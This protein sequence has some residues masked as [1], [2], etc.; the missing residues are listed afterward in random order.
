MFRHRRQRHAYFGPKEQS[1]RGEFPEK[2]RQLDDLHRHSHDFLRHYRYFRYLRPTALLFTLII[3]YLLFSWVGFK[4]IGIFFAALIIMKEIV[5]FFFLLRL[6][7]RI[8]KPMENLKQGLDEVAKGN[9]D[10]KIAYDKP[11]DLDFLI[12]SFN[13]MTAKLSESEKLQAEYEENRKAL[14]ANIS[15]DLKTPIT[16]IQGYI[17]A[18]LD[19]TATSAEHKNKYLKTIHQNSIY[20]NKLIDDLFLFSKL[21][22]QKLDFHYEDIHIRAF[23]DDLMEEYRFDLEERNIRAEYTVQLAADYCIKFDGKRFH[24]A[25]NNLI[26]NAVQHGPET[27]LSIQVKLYRQNDFVCLDVQ[28]NGLGI[29]EDKLPFIFDRFYR[30]ETE[31]PK[32][33]S[34]TGLGLAIAKELVEAQGGKITV[35]SIKNEGTCFTIMLPILR[36][37]EGE[38]Y[39]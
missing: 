32:G 27:D 17:E 24:Q 34:C 19:G 13:E 20:V 14:I 1:R 23:M 5:Q 12:E 28:D 16:A 25:F 2:F 15:H 21:D 30:I 9:Y 37:S 36:N 4:G 35:S 31:R 18:L 7:K 29:P 26:S 11:N 33:F 22:M 3:L 39:Q 38:D 6:D 8:F 10:I